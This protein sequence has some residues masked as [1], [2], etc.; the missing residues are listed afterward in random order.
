MTLC[1]LW[2]HD[3]FYEKM[4]SGRVP[5]C[6]IYWRR[7]IDEYLFGN[8]GKRQGSQLI[9]ILEKYYT[10]LVPI[11]RDRVP[12]WLISWRILCLF[13]NYG[14]WQ[15]VQQINILMN[16]CLATMASGR[17]PN[18]LIIPPLSQTPSA[19]STTQSI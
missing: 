11:E 9:N 2:G 15:G 12:N 14:N 8:Y 17:V 5:N 4:A 18:W 6:L 13:G 1:D 19:P 10:C 7:Y 3:S 16:T